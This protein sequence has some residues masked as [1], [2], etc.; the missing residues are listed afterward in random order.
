MVQ[1]VV[2]VGLVAGL[3]LAARL[4]GFGD[5][6]RYEPSGEL[7]WAPIPGQT[8]RNHVTC[9]RV[10]IDERGLRRVPGADDGPGRLQV[11]TLGNSVTFG[12]GLDDSETYQALM[13]REME[14]REPGRWRFLNGGVMGYNVYFERLRLKQLVSAGIRPD[15]VIVGYCF[16]DVPTWP[17]E[18]YP[19][20]DR[21]RIVRSVRFKNLAR[22]VGIYNFTVERL[23]TQQLFRFRNKFLP[24]GFGAGP[25]TG[26]PKPGPAADSSQAAPADTSWRSDWFRFYRGQVA[27]TFATIDSLGIPAI[28][29]IWPDPRHL[30]LRHHDT[31]E[32]VC[33]ERGVPVV[34][35]QP[36]VEGRTPAYFDPIHPEAETYR[37][38]VDEAIL[39]FFLEESA[40]ADSAGATR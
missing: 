38:L 27:R 22:S 24:F 9:R 25:Q 10:T 12:Y 37:Q 21:A 5:R 29:V 8:T 15:L 14:A 1:A 34:D 40:R 2:L 6:P 3:E 35:M 19:P 4:A 26:I 31:F 33:R 28:A 23:P 17:G 18:H 30:G 36:L 7:L 39:P 13:Q 20:A 32:Q 11:L 16:N